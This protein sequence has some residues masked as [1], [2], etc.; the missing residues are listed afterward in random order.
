MLAMQRLCFH[1]R[2]STAQI[3]TQS[4][5][6]SVVIHTVAPPARSEPRSISCWEMNHERRR[7]HERTIE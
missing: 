1:L 2:S 5:A 3:R 7:G 6:R 4:A